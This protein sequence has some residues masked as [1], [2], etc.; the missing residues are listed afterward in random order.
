MKNFW[1]IHVKNRK[2]NIYVESP[3]ILQI[4]V[5]AIILICAPHPPHP[6]FKNYL[7]ELARL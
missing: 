5:A 4:P 6:P 2:V 1:L 3:F 7:R